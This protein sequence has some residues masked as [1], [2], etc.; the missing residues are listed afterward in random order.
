MDEP[1]QTSKHPPPKRAAP[2]RMVIAAVFGSCALGLISE[3]L[4]RTG[5]HE[6]MATD[7][8]PKQDATPV[9][10]AVLDSKRNEVADE[11]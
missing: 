8:A 5:D 9:D 2:I 6:P 3:T 7:I 10:R 4:H 1:R 11:D